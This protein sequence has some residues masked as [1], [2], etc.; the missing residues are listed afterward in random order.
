MDKYIFGHY[1]ENIKLIIIFSLILIISLYPG[2][3]ILGTWESF[4]YYH[5]FASLETPVELRI[6]RRASLSDA[7]IFSIGLS[8]IVSDYFNFYPTLY[9]FRILSVVYGFFT[10]VVFFIVLRRWFDLNTS[11]ATVL[12]LSINPLFY[13]EQHT[14]NQLMI[15]CLGFILL[16]ERLQFLETQ[17]RSFLH[18]LLLSIPL[19]LIFM[20]YGPGRVFAT[21]FI[22]FWFIKLFFSLRAHTNG[23][24]I[25]KIYIKNFIYTVIFSAIFL[26]LID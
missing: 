23:N 18:W 14:M 12:L 13:F 21:L 17:Y 20:H 25:L 24:K 3:P 10:L 15:S 1:K 9:I 8:R 2:I 22:L 7:A 11:L 26:I 4:I 19:V 16:F 5:N 6:S